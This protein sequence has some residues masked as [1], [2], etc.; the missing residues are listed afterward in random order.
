MLE[1]PV[2]LLVPKC[3]KLKDRDNQQPK[4]NESKVQRLGYKPYTISY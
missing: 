2:R 1:T 4:L 3:E